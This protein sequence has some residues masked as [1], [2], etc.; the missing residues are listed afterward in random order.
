MVMASTIPQACS[1]LRTWG[2]D[3]DGLGNADFCGSCSLCALCWASTG[4]SAR[5][6]Q[7]VKSQCWYFHAQCWYFHTQCW[8]F[9]AQQIPGVFKASVPIRW[10]SLVTASAS[11]ALLPKLLSFLDSPLLFWGYLCAQGCS[12]HLHQ[13]EGLGGQHPKSPQAQARCSCKSCCA[14]ELCFGQAPQW[15]WKGVY[16]KRERAVSKRAVK[17]ALQVPQDPKKASAKPWGKA[18][19][20]LPLPFW[21]SW[22][23][24]QRWAWCSG[25]NGV[26]FCSK[27]PWDAPGSSAGNKHSFQQGSSSSGIFHPSHEAALGTEALQVQC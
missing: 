21:K 27:S 12:D 17:R 15:L 24:S 26:W 5:T 4:S 22:P 3:W 7:G 19:E 14:Q 9:H 8:Y 23:C 1:W 18:L 25:C 13:S 16:L 2:T 10:G 20:K 6:Q 11:A